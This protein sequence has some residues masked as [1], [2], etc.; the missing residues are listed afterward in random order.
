MHVTETAAVGVERQ[1]AARAGVAV[2]DELAG[3]LVRHEAKIAQAKKR[4]MRKGVVD[5]QMIDVL[6]GDA[7]FAE[8]GGTCD[9]E[10][11]R[12]I[13]RFHLADHRRF[14]ALAGA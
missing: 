8:R 4:Q 12:G 6:V 2:G 10:G 1:L 9:L 3:F 11:A 13:E 5:H 7:G 14:H